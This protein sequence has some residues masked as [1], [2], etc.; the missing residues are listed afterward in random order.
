MSSRINV[1]L[2]AYNGE[3]Y[4]EQQIQSILNQTQKPNK[5]FVNIDQSSDN[6]VNIVKRCAKSFNEI[7]ILETNKKFGSAASN[8]INL[9]M[10]VDL[11]DVDY[12]ALADQDDIWKEDKLE[13]AIQKLEQGYDGY[14]SNV[15]AFWADGKRKVLIKNQPQQNFDHL[16]ESAGPGCTFVINKKLATNLQTFLENNQAEVSQMKQY[17]DWLIYAFAR[18][19]DCKWFIDCYA[20]MQYRQHELNAFGAHVGFAGF[21]VRFKRVLLGEGFDQVLRLIKMLKLEKDP[22]VKQWYPLSRFGFLRLALYAPQCRRRLREKIYFFF[23]C[24]LLAIIFPKKLRT[25]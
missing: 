4:I 9:L 6:T 21:F 15:E 5:I 17:H 20:G 13:K 10:R 24:I 16:F 2:A 7:Q 14:S 22:F 25:I 12:I 8:F 3:D 23:A 11:N 18:T 19:N 1:L